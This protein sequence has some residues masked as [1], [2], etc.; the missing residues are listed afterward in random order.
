[1]N[2]SL[3]RAKLYLWILGN[4]RT[5]QTNH[6]WAIVKRDLVISGKQPY[7]SLFKT[8]PRDTCREESINKHLR[9]AKH[10]EGNGN[11]GKQNEQKLHRAMHRDKNSWQTK[12]AETA[13][14]Y[15]QG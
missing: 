7:E 2:V 6:N 9:Q 1:M 10:A 5:L 12:Q 13:Q 8:A 15:A 11:L 4:A 3:T 14:S